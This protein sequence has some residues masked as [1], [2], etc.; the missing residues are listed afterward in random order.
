MAAPNTFGITKTDLQS[1]VTNLSIESDTS[2]NETQVN[3]LIEQAASEMSLEASAVGIS[4]AG[5][6]VPTDEMYLL[7]KR[8]IIYRTVADILVARNRG[9]VDSA[10][11][12]IQRHEQ[13][14]DKIRKYPDRVANRAEDQGPNKVKYLNYT[15]IQ[16]NEQFAT[17]IAGRIVIGRSL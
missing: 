1:V 17:S 4:L 14:L 8:A 11:Y 13:M 12:Y 15:E 2:P 16:E 9:N 7:F 5:L 10:A 6:T 3:D